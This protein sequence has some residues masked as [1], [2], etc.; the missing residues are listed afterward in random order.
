MLTIKSQLNNLNYVKTQLE[1]QIKNTSIKLYRVCLEDIL[2]QILFYE[3]N[4][5][6]TDSIDRSINN[7]KDLL[8]DVKVNGLPEIFN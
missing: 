5:V 2:N 8:E 7:F 3:L 1:S 6:S 4:M